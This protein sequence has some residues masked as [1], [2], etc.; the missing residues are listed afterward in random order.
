[1]FRNRKTTLPAE[2]MDQIPTRPSAFKAG[3]VSLAA[4]LLLGLAW[5]AA[6]KG[7]VA[8]DAFL[9]A[10]PKIANLFSQSG[11]TPAIHLCFQFIWA[12]GLTCAI[13][14]ALSFWRTKTT[15]RILRANLIVVYMLIAV[16]VYLTWHGAFSILNA[17][18]GKGLEI[19]G[20]KQDN[21]TILKLWWKVSWP[22]LAA[23][24]YTGWLHV[25]LASRSVYAAFTRQT[26]TPLPGDY[27]LEDLRTHGK[28]PRQRRS[29]YYSIFTHLTV[30]VFLP[31]LLHM[32]GC[33]EAYKVPKGPGGNPVVTIV[34]KVKPK[35]VKKKK[36]ALR[37]DSAIILDIPDLDDTEVDK[38]L[39]EQTQERYVA[40]ADAGKTGKKTG[41]KGGGWPEGSENYKFR[42]I[43]L[44][45]GGKGWD[46][47]MGKSGADTNFMRF[48]AKVT[49]F[50]KIA[51]KGE[52]HSIALL[53]K[54]PKDGFPPF[55]YMTGNDTMGRVSSRDAKILR[56]YCLNGGMLIADAGSL[57]FHRSFVN[58]ITRQVFPDKQLIDISDDDVLYQLPFGFPNGA[59]AFWHH[60]GRR[61]LGIKHKGR[62]IVFYHPGDMNDAWKSYP[63]YTKA[64]KEMRTA[65]LELG[66]NLV[67]YAFNQWDD[68][69]AKA[70]K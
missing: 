15:Y 52:S 30:I 28:D 38:I 18:N 69:V 22:A 10:N 40:N 6:A 46:D 20:Q 43:R 50:K 24:A 7:P 54:Y 63:Q 27:I 34:A 66:V 48:F 60:G 70:K 55:V 29:L 5:L 9:A 4:I 65:A 25:M 36:L 11:L 57:S 49:G 58:F 32:G 21:A 2:W 35:K 44:N 68:A 19:W 56:D 16:Y 47:G 26:G 14:G 17:D 42:F 3:V 45:H 61:A 41:K 64:S 8:L 67:Y 13:T 51:K 37:M 59:P 33:V 62:W 23:A 1:M 39:D 53:K 31:F 12:L